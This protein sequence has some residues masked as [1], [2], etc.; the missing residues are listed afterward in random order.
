MVGLSQKD[1]QGAFCAGMLDGG[2]HHRVEQLLKD[3][4]SRDGLRYLDH[5]RQV[6]LFERRRDRPSEQRQLLPS[7]GA[8]RLIELPDLPIGAPRR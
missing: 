6:E 2:A 8:D 4:F 7:S 3:H 1:Q 5:G